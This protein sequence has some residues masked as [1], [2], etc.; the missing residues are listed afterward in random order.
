[1]PPERHERGRRGFAALYGMLDRAGVGDD[2]GRYPRVRILRRERSTM[3]DDGPAITSSTAAAAPISALA[4]PWPGPRPCRPGR[5][6]SI[7][8]LLRFAPSSTP[9]R[10][11]GSS[12]FGGGS[13]GSGP[14][15]STSRPSRACSTS[16]VPRSTKASWKCVSSA[17]KSRFSCSYTAWNGPVRWRDLH[18]S[19]GAGFVGKSDEPVQFTVEMTGIK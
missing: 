12:P 11:R 3:A 6:H 1:M 10:R 15:R 14:G 8:P 2:G 18:V 13:S 7:H 16:T 4:A 9:R 17:R 5:G 19:P